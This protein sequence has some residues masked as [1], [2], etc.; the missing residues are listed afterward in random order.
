MILKNYDHLFADLAKDGVR[1]SALCPCPYDFGGCAC[2]K[3]KP[4]ILTY[5]ALTREIHQIAL[6]YHPNVEVHMIG[7]WWSPEDH[8]QI[9]RWV[10]REAPGWVKSI[11]LHIPYGATMVSQVGLPRDCRR[12]AFVHVGYAEQ[13]AR[14]DIYGHLG[15]VIAA[16]RL[17]RTV[18]DLQRGG[19][20]GIMAYSEGVFERS[21]PRHPGRA[22]LGQVPHQRRGAP[23]LR[24]RHFGATKK[25][26]PSGHS[27]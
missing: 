3:C 12:A 20:S 26:R 13:S 4:W 17:Q 27:G 10:D 14:R 18:A 9:A 5:A 7:W 2:P 22:V 16:D 15:P 1:L 21:Q 24:R 23:R 8:R 25:P 11:F 6:K 19:V